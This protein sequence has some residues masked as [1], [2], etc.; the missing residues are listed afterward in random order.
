M[1]DRLR[2]EG[3]SQMVQVTLAFSVKTGIKYQVDVHP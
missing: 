1:D 2:H 3:L